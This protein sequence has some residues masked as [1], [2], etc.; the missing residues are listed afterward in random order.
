MK[1][2]KRFAVACFLLASL[3]GIAVA[4]EIPLPPGETHT[5]PGEVNAPPGDTQGPGFVDVVTVE[6]AL[7]TLFA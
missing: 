5:P 2:L 4:G 3:S 1:Q 7:V 6:G